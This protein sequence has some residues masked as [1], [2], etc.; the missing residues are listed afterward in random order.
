ML[1]PKG[2]NRVA[3]GANPGMMRPSEKTHKPRRGGMA[4]EN[5]IAPLGLRFL[6]GE[7]FP[8][9]FAPRA[10]RFRPFGAKRDASKDVGNASC[11]E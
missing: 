11:R 10:T 1:A 2:R 8:P 9:G 6:S 4:R 3:R 7:P 5:D